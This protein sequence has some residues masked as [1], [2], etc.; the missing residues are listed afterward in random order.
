M[1]YYGDI[2]IRDT[3]VYEYTP[4]SHPFTFFL[5]EFYV[6]SAGQDKPLGSLGSVGSGSGG[7][8]GG[9]IGVSG[10]GNGAGGVVPSA[11]ERS[12]DFLG[13][14]CGVSLVRCVKVIRA[15]KIDRTGSTGYPKKGARFFLFTTG[16]FDRGWTR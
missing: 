10:V 6:R 14:F 11:R 3:F 5:I 15:E 7:V 9:A 8:G 13:D 2:R 12:S 4:L 1:L 16:T